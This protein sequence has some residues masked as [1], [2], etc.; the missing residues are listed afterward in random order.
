MNDVL[1]PEIGVVAGKAVDNPH[2]AIQ[3]LAETGAGLGV[4]RHRCRY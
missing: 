2:D 1:Q 3:Y 4:I